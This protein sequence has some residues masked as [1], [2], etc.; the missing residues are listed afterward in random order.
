MSGISWSW[1]SIASA[2]TKAPLAQEA[3]G[4]H[5]TDQ[6]KKEAN[7][8]CW[9]KRVASP[10]PSSSPG[11]IALM[12]LNRDS[13]WIPWS[14][15]VQ[16]LRQTSLSAFA[17][18]KVKMEN[19]VYCIFDRVYIPRLRRRGEEAKQPP[20]LGPD[21]LAWLRRPTSPAAKRGAGLGCLG[22]KQMRHLFATW[23]GTS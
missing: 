17:P 19:R 6:G 21:Q 1:Q 10:S 12:P 2:M 3:V 18:A 8:I 4:P 7:A 23:R 22:R 13:F 9:G 11:R 5:P 15:S 16:H 20:A 14:L